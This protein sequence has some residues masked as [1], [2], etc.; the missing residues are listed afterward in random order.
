MR[1]FLN[2]CFT[3]SFEE[4]KLLH[5]KKIFFLAKQRRFVFEHSLFF[6][7]YVL[8]KSINLIPGRRITCGWSDTLK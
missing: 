5:K 7:P 6:F 4:K 1:I 8:Y 2:N 3:E